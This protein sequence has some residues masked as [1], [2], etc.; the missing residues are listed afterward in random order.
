MRPSSAAALAALAR[1]AGARWIVRRVGAIPPRVGGQQAAARFGSLAVYP[2]A[3]L[4]A[5]P[6][7]EP[8]PR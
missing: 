6:V 2:V 5:D 4:I 3:E 8:D 1:D 7:A